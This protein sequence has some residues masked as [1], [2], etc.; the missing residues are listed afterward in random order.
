MTS[1]VTIAD[2]TPNGLVKRSRHG[3]E[4]TRKVLDSGRRVLGGHLDSDTGCAKIRDYD[5]DDQLIARHEWALHPEST[6]A[7]H[8]AGEHR[9]FD[10]RGALT[11]ARTIRTSAT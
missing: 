3:A 1:L 11:A 8:V 2:Q 7:D 6:S 4:Q 10:A 9:T 5:S